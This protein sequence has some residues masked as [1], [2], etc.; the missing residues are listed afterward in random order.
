MAVESW[1]R[2]DRLKARVPSVGLPPLE[3]I[4]DDAWME[5]PNATMYRRTADA[6]RAGDRAALAAL[7]DGD[8]IWHI[9]GSGPMAG[10]IRGLEAVF[11]FFGRLRDVTGGT[12]TLGIPVSVNV[13][14]VF[15]FRD[16]RQQERWFHP[17]D[18]VAWDRLLGGPA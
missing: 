5:H 8:V 9:P 4:R 2:A 17:S 14:S 10:D 1:I 11:R 7:I 12:F 15:H 6:F 13:V 18:I 3:V 16:G